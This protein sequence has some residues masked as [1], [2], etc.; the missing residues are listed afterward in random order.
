MDQLTDRYVN[1]LLEISTEKGTLEKDVGQAMRLS[2]M[3]KNPNAWSFL[4]QQHAPDSAKRQYLVR[5]FPEGISEHLVNFLFLAVQ[6]S[7]ESLIIPV[8]SEFTK[9]ANRRLGKAEAIVV[10]AKELSDKQLDAIRA[11]LSKKI[12]LEIHI[13]LVVDPDIVGGFYVLMDGRVFDAT[14]R[15]DLNAMRERLK[16]GSFE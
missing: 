8:L 3:L 5:F 15:S 7:R 4:V 6:N 13:T 2:D 9:R 1:A 12:N 10:S 16:R 11:V 14:V